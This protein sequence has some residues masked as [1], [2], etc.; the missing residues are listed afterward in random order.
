MPI[1][2][3][4]VSLNLLQPSGPVQACSGIAP[5]FTAPWRSIDAAPRIPNLD[6]RLWKL[7]DLTAR[8]LHPRSIDHFFVNE[9]FSALYD[10]TIQSQGLISNLILS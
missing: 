6:R 9:A 1:V 4:S 3:K 2:L 8:R 7:T 5:P 10:I